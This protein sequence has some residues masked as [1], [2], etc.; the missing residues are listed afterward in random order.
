[1]HPGWTLDRKWVPHGQEVDPRID[2]K[3]VPEGQEVGPRLDMK[4]FPETTSYTTADAK[5]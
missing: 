2:R 3:W 4:W 1:M 5:A